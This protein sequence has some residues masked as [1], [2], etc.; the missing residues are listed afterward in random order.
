MNFDEIIDRRGTH[1]SKW[2]SMEPI[3]GVSPDDGLA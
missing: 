1:C 3:F 2:D